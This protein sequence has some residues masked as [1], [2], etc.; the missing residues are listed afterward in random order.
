MAISH[1]WNNFATFCDSIFGKITFGIIL[2]T[3]SLIIMVIKNKKVKLMMKDER[4]SDSKLFNSRIETPIVISKDGYIGIINAFNSKYSV[5]NFKNINSMK[6]VFDNH[7]IISTKKDNNMLFQDII[8]KIN[9]K[10]QESVKNIY[11]I[12]KLDDDNN[13][14]MKILLH[15][16][17]SSRR[18]SSVISNELQ[19]EIKQLLEEFE[20]IEKRMESI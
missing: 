20:N 16:N 2:I 13:S 8:A 12:F 6:I 14:V 4:F 1:L 15:H 17:S 9:L 10:L 18:S 7:D 19:I 3:I 5:I 11:L